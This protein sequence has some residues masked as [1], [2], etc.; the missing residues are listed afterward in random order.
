MASL[1]DEGRVTAPFTEVVSTSAEGEL[2]ID[3]NASTVSSAPNFDLFE[4]VREGEQCVHV[5]LEHLSC[6]QIA[7]ICQSLGRGADGDDSFVDILSGNTAV[8]DAESE[9]WTFA[10]ALPREVCQWRR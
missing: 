3:E 1:S 10:Y 8:G 6:E 9:D 7:S 2:A 5:F 4:A